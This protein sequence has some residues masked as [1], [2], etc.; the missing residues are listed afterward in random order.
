MIKVSKL[1][2]LGA[3][4]LSFL[5]FCTMMP[6]AAF[7]E[8]GRNIPAEDGSKITFNVK[9]GEGT[10]DKNINVPTP[11]QGVYEY[12][13]QRIFNISASEGYVLR[14]VDVNGKNVYLNNTGNNTAYTY[15][16]SVTGRFWSPQGFT[17][18][19]VTEFKDVTIDAWFEK[20][21]GGKPSEPP[22]PD[23][24]DKQKYFTITVNTVDQDWNPL[25]EEQF[26]DMDISGQQGHIN[27]TK[28]RPNDST[29]VSEF[30]LGLMQMRGYLNIL[31]NEG[32]ELIGVYNPDKSQLEFTTDNDPIYVGGG[33]KSYKIESYFQGEPRDIVLYAMVKKDKDVD[34]DQPMQKEYF[35]YSDNNK[36]TITGLTDAGKKMLK[37]NGGKLVI[38][39]GVREIGYRAFDKTKITSVDIPDSVTSIGKEAFAHNNLTTVNIPNSV[40]EM[41]DGAFA[42][43]KLES[44]HISE[45]LAQI[46]NNVFD[47][48]QITSVIIPDSVI[49][50]GEMAFSQNK[51]T[52]VNIPKSVQSIGDMAF[53]YQ[54][55]EFHPEKN[56]FNFKDFG[57]NGEFNV[58]DYKGLT[59][60]KDG[61]FSFPKKVDSVVLDFTG[62]GGKFTGKLTV[63]NPHK[64]DNQEQKG[65]TD[66]TQVNFNIITGFGA[67]TR[68]F[69][70]GDT[71]KETGDLTPGS[72]KEPVKPTRQEIL[73]VSSHRI[74]AAKG[75]YIS[76]IKKDGKVVF[77]NKNGD[78]TKTTWTNDVKFNGVL[79][80]SAVVGEITEDD[81]DVTFPT[82]TYDVKFKRNLDVFILNSGA[83]DELKRSSRDLDNKP[84]NDYPAMLETD[85]NILSE[86]GKTT[87]E[88][89]STG[90]M[91][92]KIFTGTLEDYLN[93]KHSNI[94]TVNNI[95]KVTSVPKGF[96]LGKTLIHTIMGGDRQCSLY[97]ATAR[98]GSKIITSEADAPNK[99]RWI[100]DETAPL[101]TE[102][103]KKVK[104][105]KDFEYWNG[106]RYVNM[107]EEES[108]PKDSKDVYYTYIRAQGVRKD[109][110]ETIKHKTKYVADDT[111]L[112]GYENKVE[113]KDGSRSWY[114]IYP[115]RPLGGDGNSKEYKPKFTSEKTEIPAVDTVITKGTKPDIKEEERNGDL[116]RITTTYSLDA[117]SKIPG[118]IK[119]TITEELI[120]KWNVNVVVQDEE[121][122]KTDIISAKPIEYN[123]KTLTIMG[124]PAVDYKVLINGKETGITGTVTNSGDGD[125]VSLGNIVLKRGDTVTFVVPK[126]AT[127]RLIKFNV[128][129]EKGLPFKENKTFELIYGFNDI[130]LNSGENI[131]EKD[132]NPSI[133]TPGTA[134]GIFEIRQNQEDGIESKNIKS[135]IINGL[136]LTDKFTQD[137]KTQNYRISTFNLYEL[138]KGT[139]TPYTIDTKVV[140][141]GAIETKEEGTQTDLTG[142]DIEEMQNKIK[143]LEGKV[144]ELNGK[145]TTLEKDNKDLLD[146]NTALNTELEKLKKE[147]AGL[148]S[149]IKEL[150]DE[151]T[152]LVGNIAD[153]K[154]EISDLTKQVETLN[155]KIKELEGKIKELN[156]EN[157]TLKDKI[158]ELEKKIKELEAKSNQCSADDAAKAAELEK[159]KKELADTKAELE[160][161]K[162]DLADSK[163]S[164][165]EKAK[166]IDELNKK[167]TDL[168]KKIGDLTTENQ[169]LKDKI[170]DLEKKLA[171]AEKQANDYKTS[172]AEKAKE[173]DKLKKE[174]ADTK[175]ELEKAKK[176]IEA[177]K[178]SDTEKD[179][180][181]EELNQ[182][183][184]DL[185]KK[186]N[187]LTNEN[188]GLKDENQKLKD[189]VTTLEKKVKELEE[190]ANTCTVEDG[191]KA[192]ELEKVKK[193]L[194]DTKKELEQVKKDLEDSKKSDAEKSKTIDELNKKISELEKKIDELTNSG[195]P[196]ENKSAFDVAG[197]KADN[198]DKKLDGITPANDQD[199]KK[200]EDIKNE[201][202]DLKKDIEKAKEDAKNGNMTDSEKD[203]KVDE[204]NRKISDLDKKI[205]ALLSSDKPDNNTSGNIS[206]NNNNNQ[207]GSNNGQSG[208]NNTNSS[209]QTGVMMSGGKVPMTGDAT[210]L[211][212]L[213]SGLV[214]SFAGLLLIRRKEENNK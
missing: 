153:Q 61:N 5:V 211:Y 203:K 14:K 104:V 134:S 50:I 205:N 56:P 192:E 74:E 167:I 102:T 190:K 175:A 92:A 112:F 107:F 90:P 68:D 186:V 106:Y 126:E 197:K 41:G 2:A 29:N 54:E 183:I 184:A 160:K 158:A 32:Q 164:D 103:I 194:E 113:G 155:N 118:R 53:D 173:I 21:G 80:G 109:Y 89:Y 37:D 75:F 108:I 38:P 88:V 157:K 132:Y 161:T 214:F 36:T 152:N 15:E 146:K 180:K 147:K 51:L 94:S 69:K 6:V 48:N 210:D 154:A 1:K 179:K 133:P 198:L 4:L 76:E 83:I 49:S 150:N 166:K 159:V 12:T 124:I 144:T 25:A 13:A 20:V 199:K 168:E 18:F 119:A 81:V 114:E 138:L 122:N 7:A 45:Q 177:G 85:K 137:P 209:K 135:I 84:Y 120:E 72:E 182:K 19:R 208:L 70:F 130:R 31:P 169:G 26:Q 141:E 125:V 143:E 176:D 105:D 101:G 116:Y 65:I 35:T 43:N 171:N 99:E 34:P 163:L 58:T 129:N 59:K 47:D 33:F 24:P 9:A 22:S 17:R 189:K 42:V 11:K 10:M 172:D 60:D 82:V 181:I 156:T 62:K 165:A 174:L 195:N 98:E 40:T 207:S 55:G 57:I 23:A 185:E 95:F 121:G 39:N 131:R 162:K 212:L 63:Y 100:A 79:K 204:F 200:A 8:G 16:D 206:G 93:F 127:N 149:K 78:R 87:I 77:E 170:A 86:I 44:V 73:F 3:F 196:D 142:K 27:H 46:K 64:Y 71:Q 128:V 97:L 52:S 187:D 30:M 191:K 28:V 201:I 67:L 140:V 188:A 123:D 111:K 91:Q 151:I 202:S 117:K 66:K 139:A 145:I 213:L 115:L 110:S 178:L 136:D 148:E 96:L 193:E